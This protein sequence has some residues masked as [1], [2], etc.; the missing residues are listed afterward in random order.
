MSG[1][2]FFFSSRRRHTRCALVTGVQTC[3]LPIL[4][5]DGWIANAR[6]SGAPIKM[7]GTRVFRAEAGAED[8]D[9]TMRGKWDGTL[10]SASGSVAHD[11]RLG[12]LTLR[13]TVAVDYYKLKEDGY[14]ETGGGDALDLPVGRSEEKPSEIQSPIRT[15]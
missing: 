10:Y 9:K 6:I 12:G 15:S 14:T 2:F 3:A 11:G 1:V 13:P 7:K 8:I 5:S 4:R